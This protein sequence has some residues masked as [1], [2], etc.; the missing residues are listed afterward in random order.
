MARAGCGSEALR[1]ASLSCG[2]TVVQFHRSDPPRTVA[3]FHA[4]NRHWES[5]GWTPMTSADEAQ[6]HASW[7]ER[8]QPGQKLILPVP[9]RTWDIRPLRG[10]TDPDRVAIEAD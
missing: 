6:V 1:R 2:E 4:I 10:L 9:R 5:L 7:I 3:E 8:L